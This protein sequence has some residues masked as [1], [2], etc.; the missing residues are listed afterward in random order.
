MGGS[1]AE[2]LVR[3]YVNWMAN[4]DAAATEMVEIVSADFSDHVSGQFGPAIWSVVA[5]W[6]AKSFADVDV[7]IHEIMTRED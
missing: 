5:H 3:R 1:I 4:P 6:S 7:Q 2:T